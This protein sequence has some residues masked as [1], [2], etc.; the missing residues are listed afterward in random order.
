MTKDQFTGQMGRLYSCFNKSQ[1]ERQMND[2]FVDMQFYSER[3]LEYAVDYLRK[4]E[5]YFPS[6]SAVLALVKQ[7]TPV[8]EKIGID[9]KYCDQGLIY[10]MGTMPIKR[11][12]K[13]EQSAPVS[14]TFR[15]PVCKQSDLRALKFFPGNTY[16]FRGGYKG[17]DISTVIWPEGP[18][19]A[20]DILPVKEQLA[21]GAY[22]EKTY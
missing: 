1:S 17:G 2:W 6:F 15:C 16:Q 22:E 12:G 4:F 13:V 14:L 5:Q 8:G 3:A 20:S 19:V 10:T 21:L 11:D 7:Y 18:K 9:C